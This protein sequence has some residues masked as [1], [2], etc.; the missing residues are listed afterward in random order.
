M[1]AALLLPGEFCLLASEEACVLAMGEAA[2]RDSATAD[3]LAAF[4]ALP[5]PEPKEAF[6]FIWQQLGACTCM[7]RTP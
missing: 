4:A 2:L 3:A 7:L 6:D 5:D 1:A